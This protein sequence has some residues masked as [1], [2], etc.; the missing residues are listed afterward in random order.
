MY[1][2][3]GERRWRNGRLSIEH[4]RILDLDLALATSTSISMIL[5][6]FWFPKDPVHNVWSKST[7][8]QQPVPSF[9]APSSLCNLHTT[10][11]CLVIISIQSTEYTS[12]ITYKKSNL[13]YWK[14]S[15]T[16]VIMIEVKVTP[17]HRVWSPP[18]LPSQH[19]SFET[20]SAF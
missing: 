11:A 1:L 8:L 16:N 6:R 9:L 20:F 19:S 14:Q 18:S 2:S 15:W 7:L 13:I 10:C 17:F 12:L 5:F 4:L 3:K